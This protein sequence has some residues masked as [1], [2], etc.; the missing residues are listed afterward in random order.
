MSDDYECISYT[1]LTIDKIAEK[2]DNMNIKFQLA[3]DVRTVDD[4]LQQRIYDRRLNYRLYEFDDLILSEGTRILLNDLI[5]KMGPSWYEVL[6]I[7][8]TVYAI[9]CRLAANFNDIVNEYDY[10]NAEYAEELS[11]LLK[12]LSVQS[13]R[14]EFIYEVCGDDSLIRPLISYYCQYMLDKKLDDIAVLV[15]F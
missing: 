7:K 13:A 8:N 2:Y 15:W 14:D 1:M 11:A 12:E 6:P 9:L 10:S 3:K 4:L 5:H